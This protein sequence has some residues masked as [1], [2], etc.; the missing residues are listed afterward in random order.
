M[1]QVGVAQVFLQPA[2][3]DLGVRRAEHHPG[4]PGLEQGAEA[5]EAGFQGH[6]EG[7]SG[8]A[9]V[10]QPGAGAAQ[11]QDLGVGAGVVAVHGAVVAQ[12]HQVVVHDQGGADGDFVPAVGLLAFFDGEPHEMDVI[13]RP[14]S[15]PPGRLPPHHLAKG[16]FQLGLFLGAFQRGQGVAQRL[17]HRGLLF[18]APLQDPALFAP[19]EGAQGAVVQAVPDRAEPVAH[20]AVVALP[21]HFRGHGA[22]HFIGQPGTPFAL[23]A[24]E[25]GALGQGQHRGPLRV[26]PGP[27]DPGPPQVGPVRPDPDR[28]LQGGKGLLG[29]LGPHGRVG[30]P[31]GL[32]IEFQDHQGLGGILGQG[33]LQPAVRHPAQ[34]QIEA[35]PARGQMVRH[36]RQ[37]PL[38]ALQ[39]GGTFGFQQG[40]QGPGIRAG[41]A[42]GAQ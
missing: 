13:A 23:G 19:V 17:E 22:L 11:G 36:G 12:G 33:G 29:R 21:L 42:G 16:A 20:G 14:H 27:A 6:V 8:H 41:A 25:G 39:L 18:L 5:H 37:H 28:L 1:V 32:G 24:P 4:H 2:H 7:G 35:F 9:V 30:L 26:E 10:A 31:G 38:Q 40:G 3:P 15:A 34:E